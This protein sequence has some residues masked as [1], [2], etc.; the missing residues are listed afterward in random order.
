MNEFLKNKK[1]KLQIA[2]E[3]KRLEL[4]NVLRDALSIMLPN[5]EVYIFGSL[6]KKNLFTSKSDIDIALKG[7]PKEMSIYEFQD[8]L[9]E[10]LGRP[11]DV[12]LLSETRLKDKIIK[13]GEL[14]K[15]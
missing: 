10:K 6:T 12:L 14:W 15:I 3:N 4:R 9:S 7:E 1:K 2:G 8:R 13:E 5:S 11:V